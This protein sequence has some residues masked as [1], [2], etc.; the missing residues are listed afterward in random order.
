MTAADRYCEAIYELAEDDIDVL[1]VRIAERLGVSRPAVSEM[2]SRLVAEGLLASADGRLSLTDLGLRTA[3]SAVRR[4]RLAERFLVD[5]LHL[6]WAEAH[7]LAGSWQHVIDERTEPALVELLGDPATCPHG[8]PIPARDGLHGPIESIGLAGGLVTLASC[9]VGDV[10]QVSRV[11]ERL[12]NEP[13]MLVA[14]EHA[15][16]VPGTRVEVL[17]VAV[18]GAMAVRAARGVIALAASSAASI[19]VRP[20]DLEL[21]SHQ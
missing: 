19:L 6:G 11:T 14:L 8:N 7:E 3:E 13:G 4:H 5:V 12:E 16:L 9:G 2:T 21:A 10:G 15:G 18:D 1:R 17:S 20:G